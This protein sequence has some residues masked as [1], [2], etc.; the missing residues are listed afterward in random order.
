MLKYVKFCAND[1]LVHPLLLSGYAA[2]Q[3][4]Y[5]QIYPK[6][7]PAVSDPT[8]AATMA[9]VGAVMKLV[10]QVL[11]NWKVGKNCDLNLTCVDGVMKVTMSAGY[12][13]L[14]T[15]ASAQ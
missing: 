3:G 12:L 4:A 13:G 6:L 7:N 5:L 10:K 2:P 14:P 15:Q 8:P 11:R 9:G 1:I